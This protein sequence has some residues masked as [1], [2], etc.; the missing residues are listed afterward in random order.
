MN[1]VVRRQLLIGRVV[2][3]KL[4]GDLE[5]V[6]AEQGHPRGAVGLLQIAAGGQRRAAV[7][8][9]DIVEPEKAA[10][11]DI[12]A[13]AVFA[14]HPPA[15]IRRELAEDP[16][17]EVEVCLALQYLLHP[18]YE[19]RGPGLYRRI[20]IAEVPLIGRDL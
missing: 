9:A 13:E 2:C 11:E 16:L 5:H 4:E 7:E 17:Q 20:D 15:E 12:L 18:V 3:R 14:V 19:D 1:S 8:D 10:L 6:L